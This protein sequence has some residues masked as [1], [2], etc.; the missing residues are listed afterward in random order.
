MRVY[1][2]KGSF[3]SVTTYHFCCEY[4]GHE[5]TVDRTLEREIKVDR[6]D[7]P[8]TSQELLAS[9]QD[10]FKYSQ[11]T[12]LSNAEKWIFA[13]DLFPAKCPNCGFIPTYM[14]NRKQIISLVILLLII[15]AGSAF[16]LFIPGIVTDT[17]M[18]ITF[19]LLCFAPT[20]ALVVIYLGRLN[21]NR[22]L[23]RA[24][25]SEGRSLAHPEKPRIIFSPV[26]PK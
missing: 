13:K 22:K 24:L 23:M 9:A 16:P 15:L 4:C 20:L 8:A 26:L 18:K 21:P 6:F 14:V 19:S 10:Q 11:D 12:I 25:A 3:K 2:L 5:H 7:R 17:A 1:T